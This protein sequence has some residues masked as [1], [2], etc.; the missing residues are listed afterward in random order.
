M[1]SLLS[2][3]ASVVLFGSGLAVFGSLIAAFGV[4][5]GSVQENRQAEHLLASVTGGDAYP[6]VV[7]GP[8][9]FFLHVQG[10]YPLY[11]VSGRIVDVVV[12]REAVA[13][14]AIQHG[15]EARY[16][17][18]G[19]VSS[20]YGFD[21]PDKYTG[22]P[23]TLNDFARRD[24]YRFIIN[25]FTRHHTFNFRLALEP[26][27]NAKGYWLHAWQV[28]RDGEDTALAES[29]PADFP[30]NEKN[31]VDFLLLPEEA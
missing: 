25:F 28:F 1:K 21:I 13:K 31:E 29:I 5:L 30:R 16:F 23:I 22:R 19:T 4:Y 20:A 14:G 15:V 9:G 26:S 10:N 7:A 18:V 3:P 27:P 24:S 6:C 17:D 8:G 12:L 11:E 2:N